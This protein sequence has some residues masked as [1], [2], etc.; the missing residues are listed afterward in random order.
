MQRQR[1]C[2][3]GQSA[4]TSQ[5][6]GEKLLLDTSPLW[7]ENLPGYAPDLNPIELVWCMSKYHR[8][9]NHDRGVGTV[10]PSGPASNG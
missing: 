8:L 2:G 5:Q 1:D 4:G 3:V 6:A 10:A 7:L 9:A